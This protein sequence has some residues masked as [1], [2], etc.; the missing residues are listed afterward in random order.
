MNGWVRFGL[1]LLFVAATVGLCIVGAATYEER[2]PYPPTEDLV[3]N[4]EG[5]V[6]EETLV[7]G[8]FQVRNG[9]EATIR[10][11]HGDTEIDVT[12]TDFAGQVEPGGV[13]QV[14]GTIRPDRVLDAERVV[15]VNP[16]PGAQLFKYAASGLG[17]LVFLGVFF[18]YW[19]V[20]LGDLTVEVRE[21][22]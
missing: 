13:V 10:V 14:A 7:F 18:R 17:A 2:T 1:G 6:G 12:V 11:S 21:D 16:S 3:T 9:G 15:V 8:T 4:Y 20:N 22:G 5:F 19:R